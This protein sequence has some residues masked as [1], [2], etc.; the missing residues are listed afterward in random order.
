M[1][2]QA[3]FQERSVDK[4][5][6]HRTLPAAHVVCTVAHATVRGLLLGGDQFV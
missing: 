2:Q 1:T 5:P 6:P 3:R 4:E